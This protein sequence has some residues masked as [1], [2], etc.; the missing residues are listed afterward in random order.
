MRRHIT[1]GR[2]LY[3]LKRYKDATEVYDGAIELDLNMRQL[4]LT[5]DVHIIS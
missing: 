4:I 1:E 5:K 2:A 3:K